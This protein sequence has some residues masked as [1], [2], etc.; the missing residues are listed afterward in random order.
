MLRLYLQLCPE[1]WIVAYLEER[2]VGLV[3]AI[4]YGPFAYIGMM[5]VHPDTQR[6]GVGRVL[7]EYLLTW[8]DQQK[9]PTILLDATA[10]GAALYT[11]FGFVDDSQVIHWQRPIDVLTNMPQPLWLTHT[12]SQ[13]RLAPLCQQNISAIAQFDAPF[14]GADRTSVLQLFLAIYAERAFLT[15]AVDN[16]ITGYLIAQSNTLGAWISTNRQD[17]ETLLRQALTLPFQKQTTVLTPVN[18][19]VA[20]SLLKHYGFTD[21][22][23]LRHMRRGQPVTSQQREVVYGQVSFGLG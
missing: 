7:L 14:F 18:N 12:T 19:E 20:F 8:L 10:D 3:G 9:C 1:S 13:T 4:H 11:R 5:G 17:A 22:R 21:V 6:Q 16:Q 23:T 15:R 2:V